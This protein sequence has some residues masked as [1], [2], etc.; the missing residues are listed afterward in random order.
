MPKAMTYEEIE[1]MVEKENYV[2]HKLFTK[3]KKNLDKYNLS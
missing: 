1:K 2:L 3:N